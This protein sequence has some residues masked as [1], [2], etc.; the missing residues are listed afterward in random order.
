M[1]LREEFENE[2]KSKSNGI[3]LLFKTSSEKYIKWLEQKVEQGQILHIDSVS[4]LLCDNPHCEDGIVDYCP[5]Y[6]TPIY[7]QCCEQ[8][9]R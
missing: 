3:E 4:D 9:D 7:C 5:Y 6:K 2:I 1:T 8:G